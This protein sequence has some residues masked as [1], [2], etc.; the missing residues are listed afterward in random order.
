MSTLHPTYTKQFKQEAVKLFETSGKSKAQIARDLNIPSSTLSKWYKK[1]RYLREDA[2]VGNGHKIAI[3][4][5]NRK[6]RQETETLRQEVEILR[7]DY[8]HLSLTPSMKYQFIDEHH[9]L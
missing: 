3:E 7:K 2:F 6:L 5:Q 8:E 1:F 9:H 4:E